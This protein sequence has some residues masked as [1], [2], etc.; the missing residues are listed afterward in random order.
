MMTTESRHPGE[1]IVSEANGARSREQG[2]LT[3]GENLEAGAVVAT[4]G[5]KYVE[6]DPAAATGAEVAV[7]V[8]FAAVDASAADADCLV[9][10]RDC[11]VD[12][13]ALGWPA[14]ITS[15]EIDT[16]T[17]ELAALGIIVR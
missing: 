12:G 8:L 17:A 3:S 10:V 2:V 4:V 9:H 15:G 14:G 5:G 1:H 16:A 13:N 11:E 6:L 7:G